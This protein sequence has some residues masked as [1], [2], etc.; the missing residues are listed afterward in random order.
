MTEIAYVNGSFSPLAEARI[1]VLDRGFLFADGIY[2]VTAVIDGRPVDNDLHMARLERSVGEIGLALPLPIDAIVALHDELI[3]R[4][5]LGEGLIYLQVTRG[6]EPVRNFSF[7]T[8]PAPSLVMFTQRKALADNPLAERGVD[9]RAVPDL[10]W[11]RR[12]IK[13]VALLAQVLAKQEAAAAGCHEA[14]MVEDGFVTEGSSSTAFIVDQ[15][16]R[17]VTRPNSQ[18]ILPGCTR[19][20]LAALM[21]ETGVGIDERLFLLD[22]AYGAREAFMTSA[23]SFVLPVVRIDGRPIGDGRPGPV[24]RRLRELYLAHARK[25][26]AATP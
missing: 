9:V 16:G 25:D 11:A 24:A 15:D 17:I 12:D 26:A 22:E 7:P 13:S 4:A 21:A 23:G 20:A 3:A 19:R 8:T 6:P 14:W 5:G 10:R 18:S 2:E 1:S